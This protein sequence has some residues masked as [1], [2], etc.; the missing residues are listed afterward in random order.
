MEK[1]LVTVPY[2]DL[3]RYA[4]E[5]SREETRGR[6]GSLAARQVLHPLLLS[7]DPLF[8]HAPPQSPLGSR[9]F[10]AGRSTSKP[11]P[12]FR[13]AAARST[14]RLPSRAPHRVRLLGRRVPAH[15]C[16]RAVPFRVAARRESAP[17]VVRSVIAA[18]CRAARARRT[19]LVRRMA[20]SRLRRRR[21]PA[22]RPPLA[23]ILLRELLRHRRLAV[24]RRRTVIPSSRLSRRY[25]K[26]RRQWFRRGTGARGLS[27]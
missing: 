6:S 20:Q 21:S 24:L 4:A 14:R 5:L 16:P 3:Q 15:L 25:R 26:T 2:A 18:E 1:D 22:P 9:N 12:V 19:G 27:I 13:T 7:G 17:L 10:A 23:R 8:A 11:L